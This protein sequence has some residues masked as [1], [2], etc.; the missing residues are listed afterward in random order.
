MN[1]D[2]NG[3]STPSE[4]HAQRRLLVGTD[5]PEGL[6]RAEVDRAVTDGGG[7]GLVF[8]GVIG[9]DDL[10][11]FPGFDDGH[12]AVAVR[13]VDVAVRVDGGGTDLAPAL[14][15]LVL[16]IDFAGL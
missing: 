3:L 16:V 5:R 13:D 8:A 12:V 11:L 14:G 10:E 4:V 6:E 7:G 9:G 15:L 1:A 2:S